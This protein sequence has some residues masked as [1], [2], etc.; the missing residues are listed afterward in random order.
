MQLHTTR[1]MTPREIAWQISLSRPIS[2]AADASLHDITRAPHRPGG[3]RKPR[4]RF[5]LDTRNMF[6]EW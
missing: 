3:K 1:E 4:A 6:G 5:A 2:E